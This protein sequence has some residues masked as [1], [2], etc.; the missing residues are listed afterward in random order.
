MTGHLVSKAAR[1]WHVEQLRWDA[2]IGPHR[3][4]GMTLCA[5]QVLRWHLAQSRYRDAIP[6]MSVWRWQLVFGLQSCIVIEY[7]TSPY[8]G[9]PG[10]QSCTSMAYVQVI[11]AG[12]LSTPAAQK[13]HM[14][15]VRWDGETLSTWL[16]QGWHI[17]HVSVT[18]DDWYISCK[19]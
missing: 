10:Q 13:C 17:I 5:S 4:T 11:V 1:W 7:H 9:L 6:Y 8:D 12:H 14:E 2:G 19:W 16:Q 18:G 3:C 15:H